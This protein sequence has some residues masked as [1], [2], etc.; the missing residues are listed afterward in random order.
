MDDRKYDGTQ[1]QADPPTLRLHNE[2]QGCSS[3]LKSKKT[4][5]LY[6]IESTLG[7]KRATDKKNLGT[8][9]L[10][11]Y[12]WH[13]SSNFWNLKTSWKHLSFRRQKKQ[14]KISSY[15]EQNHVKNWLV[16]CKSC[17]KALAEFEQ[18]VSYNRKK[19]IKFLACKMMAEIAIILQQWEKWPTKRMQL[20][21]NLSF[22]LVN[23]PSSPIKR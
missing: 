7:R 5:R 21:R 13:D 15:N 9:H 6:R 16:E 23:S 1:T 22:G 4:T 19:K 18:K 10:T 20:S 17:L 12:S 3:Q 11:G 2:I 14:Y 8:K